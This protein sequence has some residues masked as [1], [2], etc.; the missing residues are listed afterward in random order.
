MRSKDPFNFARKITRSGA[1]VLTMP[2]TP[3][4]EVGYS[5]SS[6]RTSNSPLAIQPPSVRHAPP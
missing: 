1:A 5:I 6:W 4:S 2:W 3:E